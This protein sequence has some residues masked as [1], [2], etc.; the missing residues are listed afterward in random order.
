MC[1]C[2]GTECACCFGGMACRCVSS[3]CGNVGSSVATRAGYGI[4]FLFNA[5]L[6][7]VS[8]SDA[9]DRKLEQLAH[10]YL[11][12]KCPQG[13]CYGV[14]SVH[15]IQFALTIFHFF[16]SLLMLNTKSSN[17]PRSSIQKGWWGPKLIIY[18]GLI[19]AAFF[20][21]N[22]FIVFYS[23]Y[24][25]I[26]GAFLFVLIQLVLLTDMAHTFTERMIENWDIEKNNF[27]LGVLI[28]TSL[29]LVIATLT[30][31]VLMFVWF[32][33]DK[34]SL[35]QFF[36]SFNLILCFGLTLASISPVVQEHNPKSGLTQASIV[37][38]YCTYLIFSSIVNEPHNT[39]NK[40]DSPGS[41][42]TTVILGALFTFVAILYSTSSAAT[43]GTQL[44]GESNTPLIDNAASREEMSTEISGK[45]PHDDESI[46]CLYSYS[47]FHFVFGI[48]CMYLSMLMTNWNT[49]TSITSNGEQFVEIGQGWAAVWVKVASSWIVVLLYLWTLFAPILFP[50]REW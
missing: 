13:N 48:A 27:Y 35:N 26:I 1:M 39:C 50:E 49:M 12:I 11:K 28:S 16:L 30:L 6:S 4:L 34:C 42:S 2:I 43:R 3:I 15:R 47:F 5:I 40:F 24:I 33:K 29:I 10:G 9:W 37:M 41:R 44:I 7:W 23:N 31:T 19:V 36:I 17:D 25:A 45:Y 32:G 20:I 14:L 8:L 18:F 22:E 46:G 38:S 21:P